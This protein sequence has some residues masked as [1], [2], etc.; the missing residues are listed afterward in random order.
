MITGE[1]AGPYT[2]VMNTDVPTVAG[3]Q[4][5][6]NFVVTR[7]PQYTPDVHTVLGWV[8]SSEFHINVVPTSQGM[9]PWTLTL[10]SY[11]PIITVTYDA[12]GA[13]SGTAPG[14][15]TK[16]PGVPL[17]L[18]TNSGN[19]ARTGYV[20]AGWNTAADGSG[21][22]YD[23]GASY[24]NDALATFYAKWSAPGTV[25]AMGGMVT[26]SGAYRVH[27]FTSDGFLTVTDGGVVEYLFVGGGGGGGGGWQGG[28]G[29]AG[30]YLTGSAT[31]SPGLYGV[32]V[33]AGGIGGT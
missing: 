4:N 17:T 26:T 25:A 2:G 31:L 9:G 21:T 20:F 24:T 23:A 8:S 29:G 3:V 1:M 11:T 16:T 30:G 22:S 18:A 5:D 32:T 12:N 28:G 6:L 14:S 33:G 7:D 13:T 27:T 19:L 15:Q 10:E